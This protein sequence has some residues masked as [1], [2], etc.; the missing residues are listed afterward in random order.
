MR[1][2]FRDVVPIA[3]SIAFQSAAIAFGKQA[4][5]TLPQFEAAHIVRNWWYLASL[6]CLAMQAVTWQVTLARFPLSSA[7]GAMSLVYVNVLLMSVLLFHERVSAANVAGAILI[8]AGVYLLS[9]GS[10]GGELV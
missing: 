5:L 7:Y 8:M 10:G 1:L 2:T 4:S 3:L 6:L 9:T